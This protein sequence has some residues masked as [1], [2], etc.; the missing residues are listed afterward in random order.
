MRNFSAIFLILILLASC[1]KPRSITINILETTDLH[2]T[3]FPHDFIHNDTLTHS[4][5]QVSHLVRQLRDENPNLVLLDNGDVIQGSPAVYYYNFVDTAGKHLIARIFNYMGYDAAT[6]GNHDIEAGH[7]VYD[8]LRKQFNFPWLAANAVDVR[9]GKPYFKPYTIITKDKI[10]IAVLGLITPGIPHWLP[11]K[12]Y[13]GM[14]FE[15]MVKTAKYWIKLI[16]QKENPDLII[17]LFHAGH[18]YT[19]GGADSSQCCNENASLLVAKNV[20]GFDLILIGHDHD[21]WADTVINI[22]SDSVI[23]LD[24]SSHARYV[25]LATVKFTWNKKKHAYDKKIIPKLVK[26]DSIPADKQFLKR[27]ASD[28]RKILNYVNDTLGYLD[29]ALD[30]RKALFGDSK[31]LDLIHK[32]QLQVSGAQISFAAPLSFKAYLDSGPVTTGEMFE[33]YRYENM[34]YTMRLKGEEIDKYLEYV[35]SHWFNTM[36]SP[37]DHLLK[38]EP[39]TSHL[40]Y[41]YYNFDNAQGINYVVDLRKP[42][43]DKVQILSLSNGQEFDPQAWYT[44]ALNSYR[45]NGGGGILTKGV[46]LTPDSL[47]SRLINSTDKDIRFYLMKYFMRKKHLDPTVDYNWRLEPQQWAAQAAKRDWQLLFGDK[48]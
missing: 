5:A 2:G 48:N 37:T 26:I 9:T 45:G 31:M 21:L 17:G 39:G 15:D 34:L 12:L 13:Q 23:V 36:H 35:V 4:L 25:A 6:I 22:K 32:V 7:Q 29:V 38:F 8:K 30:G 27:F 20:P 3:I 1:S 46:G 16:Q 44:V 28:Y 24:P 43:G 40:K 47:R 11:P 19:Y 41:K 42:D 10:K 33:L 18:D 14:R